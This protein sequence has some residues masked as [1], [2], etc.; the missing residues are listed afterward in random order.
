MQ[1]SPL[2]LVFAAAIATFV[3]LQ[4]CGRRQ[5][6]TA[7]DA[8]KAAQVV[9]ALLASINIAG[10]VGLVWFAAGMLTHDGVMVIELSICAG[11]IAILVSLTA[12]G[13]LL[14]RRGMSGGGLTL[15]AIGSLP[16]LFVY[17]FLVYLDFNP[18]DWR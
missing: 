5:G 3:L 8:G 18:I 6:L 2:L 17:A 16:T 1:I 10:V 4:A 15:L 13:V 9:A 7:P 12:C 14:G 11:L